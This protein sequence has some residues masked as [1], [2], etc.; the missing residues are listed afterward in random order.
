MVWFVLERVPVPVRSGG[1]G[2]REMGEALK[3]KGGVVCEAGIIMQALPERL[4][5]CLDTLATLVGPTCPQRWSCG[6]IPVW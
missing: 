4:E 1:R 6:D 5:V 3:K 2:W